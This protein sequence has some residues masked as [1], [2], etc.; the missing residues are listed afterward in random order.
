MKIFENGK[1]IEVT[2]SRNDLKNTFSVKHH[3]PVYRPGYKQ[4]WL[5]QMG[6]NK[7]L[8]YSLG[9]SLFLVI[10]MAVGCDIR[11][12]HLKAELG[13]LQHELDRTLEIAAD[14]IDSYNLLLT[15]YAS[16]SAEIKSKKIVGK[17]SYYSH[18][19]CIGCGENQI[20]AN[21]QPFDENAMTL[22]IP[23]EW[24]HIKMGTLVIV[25]NL[26][27]GKQMTARVTDTGGFLKYNRI[28]DLSKGLYEAIGAVTDKSNI[29]IAL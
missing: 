26:D 25:K 8:L 1:L 29:E 4:M 20:M 17:V 13:A 5:N 2:K 16:C 23:A 15:E 21:G 28:A 11:V 3:K 10:I 27:N 6:N 9:I 19:G 12:K 7:V 18:D 24:K 14:N 22:A